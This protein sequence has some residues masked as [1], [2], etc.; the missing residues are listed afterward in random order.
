[1]CP[2]LFRIDLNLSSEDFEMDRRQF[3]QLV[4]SSKLDGAQRKEAWRIYHTDSPDSA[5]AYV[6]GIAAVQPIQPEPIALREN[7]VPYR[8]WGAEQIDEAALAQMQAAARLPVAVAGALMP[9]AHL[10]Y[11]LP[12]GGVL[13]T[14]NTVI[15][16]AVGV[17][18]ACR[19]MLTVYP[20]EAATLAQPDEFEQIK[21]IVLENTIFGAGAAGLNDGT[22][23]HEVLDESRWTATNLLRGLRNTAIYQLGTSGTGNHFVDVGTFTLKQAWTEFNLPAGQYLALITHSGSRGVGYKIADH[24]SKLAMSLMPTLDTTVKHLAWLSLDSEAGQEYWHAMELAGEF[25]SAN[26][27][28]IHARFAKVMAVT[29]IVSVENHHNFAWRETVNVDGEKR[30]VIVHRKGATPAGKGVLGIIPGTMADVGYIVRGKGNAPSIN[31]ASHGGGRMMSRNKAKKTI[32]PQ[33]QA[34]YLKAHGVTLLGGGLDEAP[35]AYK[36]IEKVIA[37]QSDLV[38]IVGVFQPRL[39]RMADDTPPWKKKAAPSGIVDAEG[40]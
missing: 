33:E 11:G 26:H 28:I 5:V 29:P 24:Y 7:A 3:D 36:R 4:A 19:M 22:L 32:K 15:P 37:A 10:G 6:E 8:V 13:A 35:Q 16:F 27:H 20:I 12:I 2:F 17:D 18:I 40:D 31:S 14:E 39:V 21:N 9:D 38:E 34:K 23:E 30:E 1:M 25:A